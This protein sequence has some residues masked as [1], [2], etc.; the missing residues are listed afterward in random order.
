MAWRYILTLI[1]KPVTLVVED[2]IMSTTQFDKA[3][4]MHESDSSPQD[5]SPTIN[6]L[7]TFPLNLGQKRVIIIIYN[8]YLFVYV[9]I[10]KVFQ[11]GLYLWNPLYFRSD[12]YR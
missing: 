12:L 6:I 5:M 3:Y 7:L 9:V 8:R 10:D 1:F 11:K 2:F 4:K